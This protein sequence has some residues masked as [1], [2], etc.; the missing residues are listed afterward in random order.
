MI[1]VKK[2]VGGRSDRG[3][4][5]ALVAVIGLVVVWQAAPL[6]DA[7]GRI[8]QLPLDGLTFRGQEVPLDALETN[9]FAGVTLRKRGYQVGRTAVLLLVVDGTRNRHAVHDPAYCFRGGGWEQES[10]TVL[11]LLAGEAR[12]Q[13]F[14]RGGERRE[15]VHWFSDGKKRHASFAR[16]A[17]ESAIRRV[18]FGRSAPAS[19]LVSLQAS[20][21]PPPDWEGLLRAIPPLESL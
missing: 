1:D 20:G 16:Y 6:E 9:H 18:T 3:L 8:A 5:V 4:W 7:G 11:P 13:V 17:L 14:R 12:R 19:V 2:A 10:D 21:D 15:L